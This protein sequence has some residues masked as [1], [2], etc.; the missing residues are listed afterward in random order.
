MAAVLE[1]PVSSAPSSAAPIVR[2]T[3]LRKSY[4]AN[5]ISK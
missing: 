5:E 1:S 3:A 4:G 2:V